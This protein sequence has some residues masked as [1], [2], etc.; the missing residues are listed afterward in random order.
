MVLRLIANRLFMGVLTLLMAG[1]L[2]FVFVHLM[3]GSP[4]LVVKGMGAS[5][6][7]IWQFDE[8]IGWHKPLYQQFFDW[9]SQLAQ[10]NLG[11]SYVD[12]RQLGQDLPIRLEVTASLAFG[13]VLLIAFV[14]V[15]LGVVAAVRGGVLDRLINTGSNVLFSVPPYWL[16]ILLILVFAVLNPIFPA[17]GYV[18]FSDDPAG[19]AQSLV[20]PILA[21]AIPSAA[22]MARNTRAAVYDALSQEHLR[23]LRAMG[24]PTWRLIF[25]HALRFASVQIVA[26]I[27]LNFVLTFG[28]TVM[29]EQ[30]FVL[31]GLG[32]NAQGAIGTHDIPAIQVTVVI[33]TLVVVVTNLVTEL[34]VLFLNPKIRTR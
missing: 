4:G 10:G 1:L 23:T 30:L 5:K 24:T 12:G 3:P 9:V 18:A 6:E 29:I 15:I 32:V 34:L 14:G 8:S 26:M 13:A 2:S 19:W 11:T 7:V 28:G 16:A 25:V 31:P 33:T 22:G 27:G 21:I 17:T 20:L